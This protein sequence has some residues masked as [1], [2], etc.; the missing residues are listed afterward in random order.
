MTLRD[1][2]T[3][4]MTYYRLVLWRCAVILFWC[5]VLGVVA[6]LLGDGPR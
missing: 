5:L 4:D 2:M 1:R 6:G 3:V